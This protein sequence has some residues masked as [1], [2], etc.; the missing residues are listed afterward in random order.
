[1]FTASAIL[2]KWLRALKIKLKPQ[3][4]EDL[5]D[6]RVSIFDLVRH[7]RELRWGTVKTV[8]SLRAIKSLTFRISINLSM[9]FWSKITKKFY[10][11]KIYN[12]SS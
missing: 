1:M 10:W 3:S 6:I 11:K 12:A 4:D 2:V 8:V 9:N 7:L 5:K